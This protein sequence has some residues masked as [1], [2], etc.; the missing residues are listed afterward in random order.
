MVDIA[1]PASDAFCDRVAVVCPLLDVACPVAAATG[2]PVAV[3]GPWVAVTKN[4]VDFERRLVDVVRSMR[5]LT[6]DALLQRGDSPLVV[7]DATIGRAIFTQQIAHLTNS[8]CYRSDL[9]GQAHFRFGFATLEA[10]E[11]DIRVRAQGIE[12]RVRGINTLGCVLA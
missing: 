3:D 1:R 6:R 10:L 4:I 2:P 12:A 11:A 9:G 7:V 8:A 5:D